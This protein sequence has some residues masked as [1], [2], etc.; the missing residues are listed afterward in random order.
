MRK[1]LT[2]LA[3]LL[4]VNVCFADP[5]YLQPIGD[6]SQFSDAA[7]YSAR[8]ANREGFVWVKGKPPQKA[9]VYRTLSTSDRLDAEFKKLPLTVQAQFYPLKAAVKLALEQGETGVAAEIV[10][11]AAVPPEFEGVRAKLLEFLNQQ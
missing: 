2:F 6:T 9:T 5:Y 1:I 11:S 7:D 8:P 3:L 10:R 4:S